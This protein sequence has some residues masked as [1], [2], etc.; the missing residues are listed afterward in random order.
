[1]SFKDWTNKDWTNKDWT[2]E[3]STSFYNEFFGEP[4]ERPLLR[5]Q[6]AFIV[7]AIIFLSFVNLISFII[8]WVHVEI[9]V[10]YILIVEIV[11]GTLYFGVFNSY[12]TEGRTL[13]KRIFKL[14]VVDE[15]GNY[16]SVDRAT[17][18]GLPIVLILRFD[19]I[20][21]AFVQEGIEFIY[22][23]SGLFI[24]LLGIF[25]FSVVN[26]NRQALHDLIVGTQVLSIQVNTTTR[27][28]LT[29]LHILGFIITITVVFC[30][31]YLFL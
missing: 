27:K 19:S 25:Y 4:V 20:A 11:I 14:K 2:K 26:L 22:I 10:F 5:R 16:I 15:D 8:Y 17:L 18:R 6:G 24:F 30:L 31:L 3:L 13:G 23:I 12:L 9:K 7:D 21:R 28:R 29:A 1:M